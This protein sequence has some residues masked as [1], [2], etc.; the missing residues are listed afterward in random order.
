MISV[1]SS[2]DDDSDLLLPNESPLVSDGELL[3]PLG[4]DVR[5]LVVEPIHVVCVYVVRVTGNI[6]LENHPGVICCQ[7]I[8]VPVLVKV[9]CRS[10]TAKYMRII[11]I[12]K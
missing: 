11:L 4:G 10:V 6:R 12:S 9:L 7:Y 1:L 5:P 2:H 8:S 3:R